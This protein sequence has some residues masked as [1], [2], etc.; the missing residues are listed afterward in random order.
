MKEKNR[1]YLG[2]SESAYNTVNTTG[3]GINQNLFNFNGWRTG[4]NNA[5][6]GF[7]KSKGFHM[8]SG[9]SLEEEVNS[10]IVNNSQFAKE[11][12]LGNDQ[13]QTITDINDP[14]N[15]YA[16][17]ISRKFT[18]VPYGGFDGWNAHRTSRSYSDQFAK[19][20]IYDGVDGNSAPLN[21]FQAWETAINTYSNPES[22]TINLFA[23]PGINWAHQNILV[24]DAVEM[25][26]T[27]RTDTLYIIDAPDVDIP[28]VIGS[29]KTDLVVANEIADLLKNA[30]IDSSYACTYYPWIQMRDAQNNVNI[31]LPPTGEVI[32]AMAYTDKVKFPWFAPAGLQRGVTNAI[33]SKY[34]LSLEARDVIY[35]GR[36]NPLA[37]FPD[38]GTAIFGQKTMLN[39]ADSALTRINV[40]RL[41]LQ[42]KVLISNIAV[43]LLF[44]QNDQ[45]T[46]DQ[47]KSK[48][49]PILDNIKRE[50]G[51]VKFEI[52][53]D[54]TLNTPTTLDR[55]EL[56]GE[57]NLIPTK[58][59]EFIGIGFTISP[60]G[61][62]FN[63][64]GTV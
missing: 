42:I 62:S 1:T 60:S 18:F 48:V 2:I 64:T 59:L 4:E 20:K 5:A 16:T 55:N 51:L 56:Y 28:I 14:T 47:F 30:G 8:D 31:Y 21:D 24:Q 52:I 7:V 34:K 23:T 44:D 41:M 46:I 37:D 49:G 26:E 9:R 6:E 50:R 36:I 43:R 57:I 38:T 15:T 12:E 35:K 22:I 58:A 33:R 3:T 27:Q 61:A 29:E 10:V 25:I 11:F 54:D 53:M 45:A 17:A 63:E 13:F 39:N 40:R 19:G 32:A